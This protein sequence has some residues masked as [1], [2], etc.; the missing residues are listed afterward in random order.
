[1]FM[2]SNLKIRLIA[3][4]YFYILNYIGNPCSQR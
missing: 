1:M 4:Y 3:A 2:I